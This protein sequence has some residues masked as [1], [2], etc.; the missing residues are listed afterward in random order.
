LDSVI[1]D[2]ISSQQTTIGR[3]EV[4][5]I[6]A[7]VFKKLANLVSI[8][9]EFGKTCKDSNA[10][11]KIA[12]SC[13]ALESIQ[14]TMPAAVKELLQD[15]QNKNAMKKLAQMFDGI[16][17]NGVVMEKESKGDKDIVAEIAAVQASIATIK[18][19][20]TAY[21][22]QDPVAL[23]RKIVERLEKQVQGGKE[24]LKDSKDNSFKVKLEETCGRLEE[25]SK[26]LIGKVEKSFSENATNEIMQDL[27]KFL[28][29]IKNSNS[30]LTMM[31]SNQKKLIS[32]GKATDSNIATLMSL[33]KNKMRP[34]VNDDSA[35][36]MI[37]N[38]VNMA[39]LYL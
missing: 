2:G 36:R 19:G 35:N 9:N 26:H 33:L 16:K 21:I 39:R 37:S 30:S 7:D 11:K 8:G 25:M 6:A 29:D 15:P 18:K 38:L 4:E 24:A 5:D 1:K 28:E 22:D 34:T 13:T 31:T 32:Q 3:D 20:L 27:S 12:N 10:K 17:D 23:A 14:K